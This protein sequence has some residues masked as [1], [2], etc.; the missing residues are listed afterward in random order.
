MFKLIKMIGTRT[1]VP[2]MTKVKID[3]EISYREGCVYYIVYGKLATSYNETSDLLFIPIE[4]IPAGSDK[5]HITGFIVTDD[6]VFETTIEGDLPVISDGST[7]CYKEDTDGTKCGTLAEFGED[8][9][10]L[11]SDTALADGKVLVAL[12]W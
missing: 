10:L 2:E 11:N 7:I 5:T 6:M 4:S 12:K 8:I 9:K 3:P 1:N